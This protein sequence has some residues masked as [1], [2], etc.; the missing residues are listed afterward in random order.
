MMTDAN[1]IQ[2]ART[3]R[4]YQHK[5]LTAAEARQRLIDN[6]PNVLETVQPE[7]WTVLLLRQFKSLL[8]GVLAVAAGLSFAL[9]DSG[10][11]YAILVVLAINT[12]IGFVLE[13]NAR[14]SMQALRHLDTAQARVMRD[15]QVQAISSEAVTP[16]DLLLV[17]AGELVVA[18]AELMDV[19]Q[20]EVDEST[21][22]GESLPVRK[23][24][25]PTAPDAPLGDQH[26]RL[27]KGTAI[28]AGTGRAIVT[29]VGRNTQLGKISQLVGQAQPGI[30]PLQEK[31][32]GLSKILI[33]ITLALSALFVVLGLFRGDPTVLLVETAIA[34]AI[35]AIPEGMA[36]VAT[37]ALA[38]GMMRLAKHKV[39]VKRLSAVSTLGE[40]NIIFTDKTG[41]LTENRI[42]VFSL[43]LPGEEFD[44]YVE[45]KAAIQPPSLVIAGG[46]S[47]LS[48]TDSFSRLVQLGV[49]CNNAEV[50]LEGDAY[51]ELG[52]PIEVA[53]L[54]L[55]ISDR[56]Q[57]GHLRSACP[58]LAEQAFSADTRRMA[59]LHQSE[60]G[61]F[62]A[63][64]GALAELILHCPALT[65][66]QR[67]R[68]QHRAEAMAK[69]GLRTLAFAY[70]ELT[71]RPDDTTFA[72]G[73]LTFAGLIGFLDPPR[74]TII[75]SLKACRKAGIRVV[76]VTGDHPTT[77]LTIAHQVQL[78]E[79][80]DT[81]TM[82]GK[83]L[84]P[85]DQLTPTE[86]D[87]LLECRVFARVSPAQK[88]SLIDFYQ[89]QNNVV[90][91]IGDGVNDAPAL[92]K[93]DIGIAMGLRGTQV[94]AEAADLVLK[95]DSFASVVRAIGQGRVIFENIHKF[96][97]FL[98]S[99]NLSEIFVVALAGLI[100]LGNP[101][102]PLQILFVNIITDVFPALALGVGRENGVL[103]QRP[104]RTPNSPL[105]SRSDWRRVVFYAVVIT[106]AVLGVY[107]YARWQWGYT[108]A[109]CSTLAF[110]S[111]CWTQ[112]LHVF[113]L[114]SGKKAS[115]FTNEITRN[116]YVWMALLLCV[117]LLLLTYY[118]P[119][120]HL[121]LSLQ[122]IDGKALLLLIGSGIFP[123][124][125]VWVSRQLRAIRQA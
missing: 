102:L 60:T 121:A 29:A 89:Q 12:G 64:K 21:L 100:G 105:L 125:V 92:K 110:Y 11:G 58:R 45:V 118:V 3:H 97:V 9:G 14:Q 1:P 40:T 7:S 90:G 114:Y 32:N 84:K 69:K 70:Q 68:Q 63:V 46:E 117:G 67:T 49:L 115:L 91:M 33:G 18:D 30:T 16:G 61:Y 83:Q 19:H 24:I 22:T 120:L 54:K 99:C 66:E 123:V 48:A 20:L 25:E 59:T 79:P 72:D 5:G 62:V 106:I 34:L 37:I 96:V 36:V 87:Q 124:V 104:P 13:W 107:A 38:Y 85:A 35:A 39:L 17:E 101:L 41:T 65:V 8:V 113:N 50:T 86:R 95:D 44:T 82:T 74:L 75:P 23:T 94:A 57:P 51:R 56:Q 27:F 122:P 26:N 2:Q 78:V 4:Y 88:L 77:A 6:G 31:L 111:L 116:K 15:G 47:T 73:D 55:A 80:D 109:Q 10:D 98:L 28:T 43:Q 112:L 119:F 76:M 103:M 53:L 52:D 71:E 81:L 93:A 42:E 108:A